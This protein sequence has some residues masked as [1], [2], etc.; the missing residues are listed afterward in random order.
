[1]GC[2]GRFGHVGLLIKRRRGHSSPLY[3]SRTVELC[4][5]RK[6]SSST[7]FAVRTPADETRARSRGATHSRSHAPWGST[8]LTPRVSVLPNWRRKR[9]MNYG[10]LASESFHRYAETA[11]QILQ[12][13]GN[14]F[15]CCGQIA[16]K[17][18]LWQS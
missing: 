14:A 17:W 11:M 7:G 12:R 10:T 15:G 16:R 9:V 4:P 3:F 2:V 5:G 18:L 1:V 6:A 13:D 8:G